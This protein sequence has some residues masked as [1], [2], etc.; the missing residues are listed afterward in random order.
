MT[1]L[2]TTE[3][4]TVNYVSGPL[5][6]A[7]R[8]QRGLFDLAV[9]GDG[10]HLQVVRDDEAAEAQLVAQQPERRLQR[11]GGPEQLLA[12]RGALGTGHG[13]TPLGRQ[14]PRGGPRP[15][16]ARSAR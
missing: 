4:R 8:A 3:H 9:L 15:G 10:A 14:G 13:Q 16:R 7:E 12:R 11:L 1:T 6:V 2:Y 5:I